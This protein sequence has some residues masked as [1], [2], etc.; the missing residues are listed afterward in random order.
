MD[1]S[2]P[3][4]P[5]LAAILADL[6]LDEL[7][8]DPVPLKARHDGWSPA[9]QQAFIHRLALIGCVSRAARAVGKS[10]ESA[11]RLLDRPGAES[12]ASAWAKALGWGK[13]RALDI[14][15][16]RALFGERRGVYYRGRKVGEQV[17]FNDGLL[18]AAMKRLT[19][20]PEPAVPAAEEFRRLLDIIDPPGTATKDFLPRPRDFRELCRR[21]LDT[22]APGT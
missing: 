21:L 1:D 10:R 3:L 15:I 13:A 18:I 7:A 20:E 4:P 8:F 9:R 19:D 16:E 2:F 5:R 11:Y 17:R 14:G 6:P 22:A 12:F